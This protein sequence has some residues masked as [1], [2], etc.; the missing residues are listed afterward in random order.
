MDEAARFRREPLVGLRKLCPSNNRFERR[1][2][3][4]S[5]PKILCDLCEIVDR[6]CVY[7]AAQPSRDLPFVLRKIAPRSPTNRIAQESIPSAHFPAEIRTNA[8]L[9]PLARPSLSRDVRNPRL[10]C[11]AV[12]RLGLALD[13]ADAKIS[14]AHLFDFN[15][16]RHAPSLLFRLANFHALV[17]VSRLFWYRCGARFFQFGGRPW[18]RR[19]LHSSR[20]R[21]FRV[22]RRFA[23]TN[24]RHSRAFAAAASNDCD[25]ACL[26]GFVDKYLAAV[27]AH[28]P[29]KLPHTANVKYSENNVMLHL[30]D[31]LWATADGS[32]LVQDLH[33]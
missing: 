2:Y 30:G 19:F 6:G 26:N 21:A 28:D 25:R 23:A 15:L 29:S 12:R 16:R 4:G 20:A 27:V 5:Q 7:L 18:G 3:A 31:G 33:R 14:L 8:S 17:A 32:R 22:Q 10:Q 1:D 24:V 13:H 9:V 11:H